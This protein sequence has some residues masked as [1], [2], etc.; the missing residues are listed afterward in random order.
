[1]ASFDD[2]HS[3]PRRGDSTETT[4]YIPVVSSIIPPPVRRTPWNT[5]YR[6]F[7]AQSCWPSS[8]FRPPIAGCEHHSTP[9]LTPTTPCLKT[10]GATRRRRPRLHLSAHSPVKSS[11]GDVNLD[12]DRKLH[13]YRRRLAAGVRPPSQKVQRHQRAQGQW[14]HEAHSGYK[15]PPCFCDTRP[16]QGILS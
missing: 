3:S 6:C 13:R 9:H 1:M 10:P 7:S 11:H 5:C 12:H 14:H 4:S 2:L 15:I 16:A 8:C